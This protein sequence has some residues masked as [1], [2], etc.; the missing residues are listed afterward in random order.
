MLVSY[1]GEVT[2]GQIRL[3]GNPPLQEGARLIVVVTD[4]PVWAARGLT[5]AEWREPFET[6]FAFVR[7][8]SPA[9][10]EDQP[11][12]DDELNASVHTVREARRAQRGN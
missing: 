5:E 1:E 7:A 9:P 10:L 8:A 12:K 4:T 11:L 2:N 3:K 6:F